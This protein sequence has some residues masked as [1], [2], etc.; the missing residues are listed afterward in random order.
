MQEANLSADPLNHIPAA[1]APALVVM[2]NDKEIV[3]AVLAFDGSCLYTLLKPSSFE[4]IALLLSGYFVFQIEYPTPYE[5][6]LYVL[7]HLLHGERSYNPCVRNF[8]RTFSKAK[9]IIHRAQ[10]GSQ[11]I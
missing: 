11:Q 7:Q 2:I 10:Q 6:Q 8:F 4:C 9:R 5:K 1:Q 3:S